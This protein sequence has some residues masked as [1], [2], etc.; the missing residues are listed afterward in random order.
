[1]SSTSSFL[2]FVVTAP[3]VILLSEEY[4][5]WPKQFHVIQLGPFFIEPY[6]PFSRL[7][8]TEDPGIGV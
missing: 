4:I 5:I 8:F 3:N 2:Y 6:F 1:M 7:V